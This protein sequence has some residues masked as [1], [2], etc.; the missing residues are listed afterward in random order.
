M[1]ILNRWFGSTIFESDHETMKETV[2]AAISELSDLS[3]AKLSMAALR[4]A[5]LSGADLSG[6]KLSRAD[7]RGADLSG[8]NLSGA[9]LSGADLSGADIYMAA[10]READLRGAKLSGAKLSRAD[11][12]GA[13]LCG[14]A[15]R[16]AK[17]SMADLRGA[18]LFGADLSRADLSGA[19]LSM[20][21]EKTPIRSAI[22]VRVCATPENL[23]MKKWHTCNTVH[24]LAGWAVTLHPQGAELEQKYDT[25]A[26]GA[27]IFNACEGE[28]PDFYS[29]DQTALDWLKKGQNE[30]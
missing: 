7:L 28:V 29:D 17:L 22:C 20:T 14:A 23:N 10:L 6:A 21:I 27:L 25:N 30:N 5:A 4:G 11:L 19:K 1:K 24:C 9:N 26:A 16:R 18:D 15:L 12:R 3:G 13:D 8:A 2:E